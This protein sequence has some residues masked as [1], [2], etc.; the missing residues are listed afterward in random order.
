MDELSLGPDAGGA[1]ALHVVP[2]VSDVV[3]VAVRVSRVGAG[4]DLRH[5]AAMC[6]LA[7]VLHLV[8]GQIVQRRAAR[9]THVR[10]QRVDKHSIR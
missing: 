6:L 3:L 7:V 9:V 5:G 10:L 1:G 8:L 4:L 2:L